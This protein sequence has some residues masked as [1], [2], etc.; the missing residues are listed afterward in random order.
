MEVLEISKQCAERSIAVIIRFGIDLAKSSFAVCGVDENEHIVLRKTLNRKQL[1]HFFAN[2]PPALVAMEA[3]SG[4]H[5]W[6]RELRA[7]GH[8]ARIIDP[9]LVAP[10][11]QQGRTGKNDAN[12]AA[13][14][15]E[16]AARPSMSFVPVKSPEQQAILMVHR[17]RHAIV[18]EHTRTAN[19]IRGFLAEFGI[20]VPKGVQVL[21]QRWSE[22]RRQFADHLPELAWRE[23][24]ALYARLRELH[25]QTLAYDRQINGFVK[26]DRRAQRLRAING[27]GPITASAIV[28]TVG[29]A[30]EFK[31]GRQLA[32]WIGL[33][34]R[35]YST[36][37]KPRLGRISKRGDCY[38]R[39]L[40]VHGARSELMYTPRRTDGKSKW[41][42]N[43][44][45][46]MSWNKAAV[47]LA[48]K[49]ARIAW[50][51]LANDAEPLPT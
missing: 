49:H 45:A 24:D 11:R 40:L 27:I 17:R 46:R 2:Q 23:L 4:A 48:N 26:A 39:T 22:L 44:K 14:V 31:N 19:Q 3:G 30:R 33:T 43:L 21:K 29:N 28:A 32:A 25:T 20:V 35:Q 36:G 6:A 37:G 41:A 9:R 12:D 15:C 18:A 7:L 5:H 1:L 34:P 8:D 10:Y 51:V 42:E 16:A 50:A 13:A 47:A 38:L